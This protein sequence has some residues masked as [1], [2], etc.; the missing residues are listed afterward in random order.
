MDYCESRPEPYVAKVQ[1]TALLQ[2]FFELLPPPSAEFNMYFHSEVL[3]SVL[4]SVHMEL[5]EL[6][7][8]HSMAFDKP[9]QIAEPISHY[10]ASIPPATSKALEGY[11][12]T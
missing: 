12:Q 8:V 9:K 7:E 6:P 3:K 4:T 10:C 5:A 2:K 11:M 1:L